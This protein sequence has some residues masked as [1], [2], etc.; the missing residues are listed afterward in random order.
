VFVNAVDG[1]RSA[2][3]LVLDDEPVIRNVA[4]ALL[5]RLGYRAE[6]A[7]DGAEAVERYRAALDAGERFDLVILDVT[8]RGGMGGTEALK[9][10]LELDPHVQA[11]VSSG[12]SD[13]DGA[14]GYQ[15]LGFKA[16]LRK[17]YD[18]NTLRDVV[19]GILSAASAGS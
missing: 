14:V 12:Y 2:R 11:V 8:I 18:L 5:R 13:D 10:L 4:A 1:E 16:S 7:A 19:N 6:V 17:P 15:T 9:R 3:V